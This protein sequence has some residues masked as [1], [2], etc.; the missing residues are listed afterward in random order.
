MRRFQTLQKCADTDFAHYP[1]LGA[2]R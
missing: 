2:C 1:P